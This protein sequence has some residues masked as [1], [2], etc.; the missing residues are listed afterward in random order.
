MH[1]FCK[2]NVSKALL[3]ENCVCKVVGLETLLNVVIANISVQT[4]ETC[5]PTIKLSNIVHSG[6]VVILS[7]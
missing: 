5:W 3:S 6:C 2:L 7:F 4:H 1:Q